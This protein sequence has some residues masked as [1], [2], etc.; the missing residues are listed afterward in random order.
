MEQSEDVASHDM[1]TG[2]NGG[3]NLTVQYIRLF[4]QAD[5]IRGARRKY[6]NAF[7]AVDKLS[8]AVGRVSGG[9][10]QGLPT[11]EEGDAVRKSAG[12]RVGTPSGYPTPKRRAKVCVSSDDEDKGSERGKEEVAKKRRQDRKACS[13]AG[14]AQ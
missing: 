2:E 1:K 4:L 13:S 11:V 12:V 9:R 10:G 6:L 3:R 7:N 8:E 5:E 14:S